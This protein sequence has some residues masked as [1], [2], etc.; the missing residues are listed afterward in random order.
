MTSPTPEA[1]PSPEE[2]ES[3]P[4]AYPGY[5]HPNLCIVQPSDGRPCTFLTW[6]AALT[7]LEAMSDE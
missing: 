3:V 2:S 1:T 7:G 4:A 5:Q 6:P